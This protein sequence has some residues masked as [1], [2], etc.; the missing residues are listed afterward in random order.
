M[1]D[2]TYNSFDGKL[3]HLMN[4]EEL[5]K[6]IRVI[7]DSIDLYSS[8]NIKLMNHEHYWSAYQNCICNLNKFN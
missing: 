7:K 6:A 5:M 3:L 2:I 4:K 8:S 1:I